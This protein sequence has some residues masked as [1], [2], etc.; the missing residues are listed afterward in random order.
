MKESNGII[1]KAFFLC[2]VLLLGE[3]ASLKLEQEQR[4]ETSARRLLVRA[5]EWLREVMK[6]KGK[7]RKRGKKE[8]RQD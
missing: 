1:I 3:E 2:L 4:G 6:R 5:G 8:G 7:K